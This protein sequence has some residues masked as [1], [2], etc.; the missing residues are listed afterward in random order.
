MPIQYFTLP[1]KCTYRKK[2][3]DGSKIKQVLE[4]GHKGG[5]ARVRDEGDNI[6]MTIKKFYKKKNL[7][8]MNLK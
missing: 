8:Q 4:K 2:N 6:T 3:K 7:F 1:D 5:Y